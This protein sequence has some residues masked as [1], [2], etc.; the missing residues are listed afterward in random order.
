[1]KPATILLLSLLTSLV[2]VP[3]AVA[4]TED[5]AVVVSRKN[6][7]T[8]ISSRELRQIF[9]GDR[10]SWSSGLPIKLFVR[11]PGAHERFVLLTLFGMN[12]SEY[13]RYWI[14]KVFRGEAQAE[15]ITVFSNDVQRQAVL[16]YPGAVALVEARDLRPGMKVV[17]VDG[18][19]P[20]EDKYPLH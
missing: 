3:V 13:K 9:G 10:H 14:S 4:Q 1:M 18:R 5:V 6:P 17:K 11:A 8:N 16:V 19:M 7:V 20:G 12:E 2:L 15:P